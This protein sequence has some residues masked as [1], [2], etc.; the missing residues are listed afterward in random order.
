MKKNK[1]ALNEISPEPST[2]VDSPPHPTMKA[3]VVDKVFV[4]GE[5]V[6]K[7]SLWVKW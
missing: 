5:V 4:V 3:M 6:A 7:R 2:I 1:I